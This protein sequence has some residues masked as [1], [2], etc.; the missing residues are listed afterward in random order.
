M[1][2]EILGVAAF[3]SYCALRFWTIF[4][5]LGITL[6]LSPLE[7]V[8]NTI[9]VNQLR[10]ANFIWISAAYALASTAIV[11][12]SGN[13]ATAFGRK[14]CT[15]LAIALFALGSA[16]C[17]TARNIP[18]LIAG[19]A[20][21]GIG[22]GGV[23]SFTNIIVS[24]LVPLR[25]RGLVGAILNF[26]WAAFAAV[27]PVVGGA[28]T[29]AGQWRWLYY[30]NLPVCGLAFA[31]VCALVDFDAPMGPLR[32]T[33]RLLDWPGMLLIIVSSASVVLALTWS[34]AEYA[35]TSIHVLAPLLLGLA[36]FLLF[37]IYERKIATHPI[38]PFSLFTNRTTCAGY[39]QTFLVHL[40][41]LAAIYYLPAYYQACK[42]ASA[43]QSGIYTLGLSLSLG[44]SVAFGS[45]SVSKFNRYRPQFWIGWALLTVA[46]GL[47][48]T[49]TAD[50]AA[51]LSI[52]F[53]ILLS[54]GSG[55]ITSI[56]TF[57][58]LAPVPPS[59]APFGLAFLL[60]LRSFAGVWGIA[61]GGAVLQNQLAKRLP[62]EIRNAFAVSI[63]VVWKILAGLAGLGLIV[64]FTMVE[65]PMH[66][67]NSGK[68]SPT[69]AA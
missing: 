44:P 69:Q 67:K 4:L 17:G 27:G 31:L 6:G 1:P 19:R 46:L 25:E 64:S 47:L 10:G 15:L 48:S 23:V 13:L 22:G 18:W 65:V 45:W 52:G 28:L 16:L 49:V 57:P 33:L 42:A 56:T 7:L 14:P 40:I 66:T 68:S 50:S 37:I 38:T 9:V 39:I 5:A 51:P 62:S 32:E 24:D 20:I 35:W 3:S 36:G 58:I 55:V 53:S 54:V 26:T 41:S 34:G 29:S 2:F 21:Q 61:I 59:S 43:K 30:S 8:S 11:P 12:M 63:A 60:F